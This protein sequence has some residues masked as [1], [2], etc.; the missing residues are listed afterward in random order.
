MGTIYYL[1]HAGNEEAFPD[2]HVVWAV[3]VTTILLSIAVHGMSATTLLA[4]LD[5]RRTGRSA[6]SSVARS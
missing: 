6:N 1:A 5:A 4:R 3:A 2:A